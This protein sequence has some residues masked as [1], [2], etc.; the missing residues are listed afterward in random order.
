VTPL[1]NLFVQVLLDQGSCIASQ[2]C[3]N[4][5][6]ACPVDI[7]RSSTTGVVVDA[8]M[9]DECLLCDACISACTVNAVTIQRLYLV[10]REV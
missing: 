7:F 8:E 10:G 6:A 1:T 2:G 4:C 5:V 3:R 9:A